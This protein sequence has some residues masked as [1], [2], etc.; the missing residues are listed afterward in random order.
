MMN[1]FSK[2]MFNSRIKSEDSTKSERWLGYLIGPMGALL[3]NAIAGTYLNVYYTDVLG[4]TNVWNGA[5]LVVFPIISKIIDAITNIIMGYIIDRTKTKQGKA[6]P[7][8]FIS[9]PLLTLTALLLFIVP[10]GSK[11]LQIIWVM[12]SY[13][14]FYSFAYTIYN[15]SH[16]LMAPLSTRNI[17]QRNKLSVFNQI[18][19]VMVTGII[20]ALIFPMVVAPWWDID[21]SRWILIMSVFAIIALPLTLLEYYF[22]K[23]RI[24]EESH[25]K[26]EENIPFKKQFKTVMTD[27]YLLLIYGFY[28][29]YT[30]G[31]GLKSLSRTYYCNYVLGTYNDG[32]TQT[33]LSVI[34]GLPLGLGIFAVWPLVKKFGKRNVTLAGLILQ[35]LGAIISWIAPENMVIVLIGQFVRSVGGLP[36]AYILMAIFAD[37]LDNCE[38]KNGFRTDGLAMSIFGIISTCIIGVCTGIFNGMLSSTGYIQP[39]YDEL[40]NLIANQSNAVKDIITFS[41]TGIDVITG[42]IMFV[43]LIFIDVEK[44]ID[45]KQLEIK[46]RK[47]LNC[48]NEDSTDSIILGDGPLDNINNDNETLN[49]DKITSDIV[50]VENDFEK[51]IDTT[52]N[53]A[54]E[55]LNNDNDINNDIN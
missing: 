55:T 51:N 26:E 3:L 1:A 53:Q 4:L 22:T 36:C 41:F 49:N 2:S 8:L 54:N 6:R 12:L 21:A 35:V 38:W 39:Y 44:G 37:I 23:E 30:L 45:K 42:V 47:K 32:I 25:T 10:T 18:S 15:M 5:F 31:S 28:L 11:T 7:W 19:S 27:K 43:L 20:V 13:N 34:G 9:A 50:N 46:E 48:G 16:S 29:A 33:L 40:G 52:I 17:Q 14:M 24:T